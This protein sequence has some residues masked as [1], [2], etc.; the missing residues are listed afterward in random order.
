MFRWKGPNI[1]VCIFSM[2]DFAW[3]LL[4][5][6]WMHCNSNR[7]YHSNQQL[8]GKVLWNLLECMNKYKTIML[9]STE[10]NISHQVMHECVS[11]RTTNTDFTLPKKQYYMTGLCINLHY[12]CCSSEI[13]PLTVGNEH[14]AKHIPRYGMTGVCL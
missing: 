9:R 14:W 7:L 11:V 1:Y 6:C 8:E 4:L 3:S 12:Y 10:S 2:Y 13:E 5:F